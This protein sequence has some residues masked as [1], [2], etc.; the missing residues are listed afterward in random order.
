MRRA[1]PMTGPISEQPGPSGAKRQPG[2]AWSFAAAVCSAAYLFPYKRASEHAS[3]DVMALA[4]LAVAAALNTAFIGARPPSRVELRAPRTL[5]TT[6]AVLAMVTISG[7]FCGA[8]AVAHLDPALVSVLLRTEVVFVGALGV[9]L[10]GEQ[11]TRALVLG[12]GLALSGLAVMRWPLSFRGADAG[13]LWAL[14]AAA[15]F[16]FMQVFTRRVIR[17]IAPAT[18]NALRLWLATAAL[19]LVPGSLGEALA[20]GPRF[21]FYMS[22]A[23]LCGPFLGRLFIMYS[24]QTLRAAHSALLLLMAPVLAFAFSYLDTGVPPTPRELGGGALMLLGV[25]LPS[26]G[27]KGARSSGVGEEGAGGR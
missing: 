10:L 23:G 6:S 14:G 13:A 8:Q 18:V 5:W 22:A 2:A 15:S 17:S 11:L 25:A 1:D 12:A 7:N 9:L 27:A 4:L 16:A 19:T 3:P 26:L 24:L 21:W 20:A